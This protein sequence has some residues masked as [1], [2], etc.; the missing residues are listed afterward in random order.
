MQART[1]KNDKTNTCDFIQAC[2]KESFDILCV[3]YMKLVN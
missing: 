1:F 2:R 3:D